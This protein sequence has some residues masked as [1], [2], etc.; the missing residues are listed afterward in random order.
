MTSLESFGPSLIYPY[1][2]EKSASGGSAANWPGGA[3]GMAVRGWGGTCELTQVMERTPGTGGEHRGHSWG[4][5]C[6]TEQEDGTG[7]TSEDA[8]D[9]E[10]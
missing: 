5:H 10:L 9:V 2:G 1:N 3:V 6:S 7:S 8:G 4:Q